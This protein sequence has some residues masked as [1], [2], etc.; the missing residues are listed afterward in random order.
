[1]RRC[2]ALGFW[3]FFPS[4]IPHVYS[5]LTLS[6]KKKPKQK[7]FCKGR[8][9]NDRE[10]KH[11]NLVFGPWSVFQ[12]RLSAGRGCSAQTDVP[13]LNQSPTAEGQ[14]GFC[15]ARFSRERVSDVKLGLCIPREK[16]AVSMSSNSTFPIIF[17][18]SPVLRFLLP[19]N[20]DGLYRGWGELAFVGKL[21]LQYWVLRLFV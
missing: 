11:Q 5:Q 14:S 12:F 7:P 19:A 20:A 8:N 16:T 10:R 13:V 18:L 6:I 15:I 1:M 4:H 2:A 17:L 3:H 9:I 21:Y